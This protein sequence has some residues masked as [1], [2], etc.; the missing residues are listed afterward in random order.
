MFAFNRASRRAAVAMT[1]L[2]AALAAL[3]VAPNSAAAGERLWVRNANS[4]KCLA[5]P[6]GDP[7][8]GVGL[9]QWT[10]SHGAPD[11]RWTAE[12]RDGQKFW[13]S[14]TETGK[15]VDDVGQGQARQSECSVS[16]PTHL[17]IAEY[18]D[19]YTARLRNVA[20]GRCLGVEGGSTA[21]GAAAIAWPCGDA[22]DHLWHPAPPPA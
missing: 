19:D 11:H 4:G 17:W 16:S 8:A 21:D 7:S 22:R 6:G 14:N 3:L 2:V 15:C 12:F 13:L 1:C 20:T 9:I 5:V 18:V 10:C